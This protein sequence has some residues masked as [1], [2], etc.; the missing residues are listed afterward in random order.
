MPPVDQPYRFASARPSPVPDDTGPEKEVRVAAFT[1]FSM[2][3]S[4]FSAWRYFYGLLT[5]TVIVQFANTIIV[6][7]NGQIIRR[8]IGRLNRHMREL[9]GQ[10]GS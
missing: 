5:I 3:P 8:P 7:L 2:P 4:Q 6:P 9:E 10:L 1:P